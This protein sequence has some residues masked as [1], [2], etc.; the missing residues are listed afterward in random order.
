MSFPLFPEEAS[1]IARQT[2]YLYWGLIC[3]SALVCLIVFCPIIFFVFKYRQGKPADRRP[4]HLPEIRI[5]L[6]WT[7]LPALL[8]MG[9]YVWGAKQYFNIERPPPGAMEIDVVGKQWMWKVQH[10]EGNREINQLHVPL[11]RVVKL[12]MASQDVIHSFFLPAFRIKQDVVPGRYTTEWF[13][14]NKLGSYHLFCSEFCGTSHSQMTGQV[15]VMEPT[16]YE[17]WLIR[18]QPGS[19]LAQ[20]GERLF[21]ELGCSGCHIG[22]SVIRAPPLEGLFG[23]PVPLDNGEVV[24]ADEAY[25]RDSILFPAKQIVGGYTNAMPTFQGRLNEEELLQIVAYIKN[26]GTQR[27]GENPFMR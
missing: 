11:G 5:E 6:T 14:A 3:L 1:Q 4:V 2:D 19:T 16:A 15:V 20:S 21:R 25:I 8:M 12:T 17:E 27:P 18:G 10:P 9:F 13:K 22:T 23:R 26:L 7:V 24:T